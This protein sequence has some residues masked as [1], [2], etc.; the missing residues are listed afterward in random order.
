MLGGAVDDWLAGWSASSLAFKLAIPPISVLALSFVVDANY[1]SRY[2]GLLARR[3][4]QSV[5]YR[6]SQT[7]GLVLTATSAIRVQGWV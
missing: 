7:L 4:S 5:P 6:L 2:T 1:S 3:M